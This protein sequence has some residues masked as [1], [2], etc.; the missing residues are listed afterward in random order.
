MRTLSTFIMYTG[1]VV[2]ASLA[3]GCG[4]D[5]PLRRYDRQVAFCALN[6]EA[7]F[8]DVFIFARFLELL[9]LYEDEG[10]DPAALTTKTKSEQTVYGWQYALLL[11]HLSGLKERLSNDAESRDDR[12]IRR[13]ALV[14][15]G[16][17]GWTSP[18]AKAA[19]EALARR[20]IAIRFP[21]V[22]AAESTPACRVLAVTGPGTAF[23]TAP[24]NHPRA[25]DGDTIV[26]IEGVAGRHAWWAPQPDDTIE[27]VE[28]LL[29]NADGIGSANPHGFLIG[30]HD[31]TI[32]RISHSVP[33]GEL[34][35]LMD[36]ESAWI[37]DRDKVLR[38][39]KFDAANVTL[40]KGKSTPL[41]SR[42]PSKTAK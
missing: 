38:P 36:A 35:K 17:V 37:Y 34:R 15:D 41:P 31:G 28:T 3:A 21:F 42:S 14:I 20:K 5:L 26:L 6:D 16:S 10:R 4:Q 7:G 39:W 24:D 40:Q 30:F 19:I 18:E 23:S 8:R 9:K 1:L 25:L 2:S 11:W 27:H 32:W 12:V 22:D 29:G 33:A 13:L